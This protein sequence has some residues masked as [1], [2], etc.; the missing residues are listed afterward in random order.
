MRT[1]FRPTRLPRRT[2]MPQTANSPCLPE[3]GPDDE[4]RGTPLRCVYFAYLSTPDDTVTS[5]HLN[6]GFDARVLRESLLNDAVRD[7]TKEVDEWKVAQRHHLIS[8]ITE[9]ISAKL[10][11]RL[12]QPRSPTQ[13]V[14]LIRNLPPGSPFSVTTCANMHHDELDTRHGVM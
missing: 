12:I 7:T 8:L 3:S 6:S 4:R 2:A 11:L 13:P 1:T 14:A 10:P 5:I 9:L